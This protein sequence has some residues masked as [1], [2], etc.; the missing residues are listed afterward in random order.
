MFVEKARTGAR[1]MAIL[2]CALV[3]ELLAAPIVQ[4][5]GT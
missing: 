2:A 5:G 3:A 4:R 1:V